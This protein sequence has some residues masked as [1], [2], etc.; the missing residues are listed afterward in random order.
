MCSYKQIFINVCKI[1]K[2]VPVT[3]NAEIN[4]APNKA[5]FLFTLNFNCFF[6]GI[7]FSNQI[8]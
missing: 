4:N 6:L 1:N 2:M 8:G 5:V 3:A 7:M